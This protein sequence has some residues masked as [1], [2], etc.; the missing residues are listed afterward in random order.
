GLEPEQFPV[1][2]FVGKISDEIELLR[3]RGKSDGE[4]AEIIRSNSAIQIT[5][6]A[7]ARYYAPP[8]ERPGACVRAVPS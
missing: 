5:P 7:I 3:G 1:Q 6:E 4:I 2:A 8:E